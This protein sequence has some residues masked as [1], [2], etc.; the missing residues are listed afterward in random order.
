VEP[1]VAGMSIGDRVQ[2]AATTADVMTI[3][4][5]KPKTALFSLRWL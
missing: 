5:G 4:P 3:S 1:A 2:A